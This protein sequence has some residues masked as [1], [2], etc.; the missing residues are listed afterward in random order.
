VAFDIAGSPSL[1]PTIRER[2][3]AKL[4]QEVAVT[5]SEHRSQ[6]QNRRAALQ[7]LE[8]VLRSA[9]VVPRKRVATRPTLGSQERRLDDKRQQSD[10]KAARRR[11]VRGDD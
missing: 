3:V 1:S 6:Y 11:P 9:L 7:R 2:L 5:S 8:A 10:R 4:G